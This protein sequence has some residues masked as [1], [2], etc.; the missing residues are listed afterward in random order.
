MTIA[1]IL[2]KEEFQKLDEAKITSPLEYERHWIEFPKGEEHFSKN[3]NKLHGYWSYTHRE[4]AG[5]KYGDGKIVHHKDNNKHNNSKENL[6]ITDRAGHCRI[7]PNAA[8]KY[9]GKH[10]KI[11]G[12]KEKIFG[13]FLCHKHYMQAYRKGKFGDYDEVKNHSKKER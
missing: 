11:K 13:R 8:K 10:C 9:A 3:G 2:S 4:N 1:E 12:C 5:C 6:E 7:D